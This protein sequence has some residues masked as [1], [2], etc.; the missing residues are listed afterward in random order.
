MAGI[1]FHIPFCRQACHYCNFHFSTSLKLKDDFLHAI[2]REIELRKDYLQGEQVN[3]IYFG[4]GTPSLL[5]Q[6][7]LE[8]IFNEI[9]KHHK[10]SDEAE[11]TFEA[12]PDDVATGKL[13]AWKAAG[14]NRLSMGVQSFYEE[15]LKWMNRAH[16]ASQAMDSIKLVQDAGF[17]NLT[18]DLIY[19]SPGLTD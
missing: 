13:A 8:R 7:E 14:I 6:Y 3:T 11:I 4:G 1:Y 10:V 2:L 19:G 15:D 18:I 16:N 5:E 17:T 9:Y 12:N